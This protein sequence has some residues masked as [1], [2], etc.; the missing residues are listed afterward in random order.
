MYYRLCIKI[1]VCHLLP[2]YTRLILRPHEVTW[3]Q[4]SPRISAGR[5]APLKRR[6]AAE[7]SS[8]LWLFFFFFLPISKLPPRSPVYKNVRGSSGPFV[9]SWATILPH[10][11]V[12][13]H[14]SALWNSGDDIT[15]LA[16][17]REIIGNCAQLAERK[18]RPWKSRYEV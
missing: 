15:Q 18:I 5:Y 6:V 9:V 3:L 12:S 2:A 10:I 7:S 17:S 13:G 14:V 8:F 16:I 11:S 1:E 4:F